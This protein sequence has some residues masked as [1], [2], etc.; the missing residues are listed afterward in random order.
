MK[1]KF[2]AVAMATTMALSTAVTAMAAEDVSNTSPFGKKS[3]NQAVGS[4]FDVTY[5]THINAYK[6]GA[7]RYENVAFEF[8]NEG[9]DG[10]AN[11]AS[12]YLTVVCNG[13]A[14]FW[15]GAEA[16]SQ[17]TLSDGTTD[18]LSTNKC[19]DADMTIL[20][21]AD[22]VINV[23]KEGAKLTISGKV[24]DAEVWTYS[25][26]G[27]DAFASASGYVHLTGE[28][29]DLTGIEFKDNSVAGGSGTKTDD[30]KKDDA[31]TPSTAAPAAGNDAK[32]DNAAAT[33]AAASSTT[34]TKSATKTS[35][36]TGDV[37]PVAAL[38]AVAVVA[39]AGVVV[40]RRKV[41]E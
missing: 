36:K 9:V 8:T 19:T 33:T 35:P 23:K 34:T 13:G 18:S 28:Q 12:N 15:N 4:N 32:K 29:T 27:N 11:A 37:A 16:A 25:V 5:T 39:C 38:G 41:T 6:S 1:K 3:T 2:F 26:E 40:S 20:K 31:T 10:K 21:D 17:W 30:A 24:G 14:W 7:N 22:M